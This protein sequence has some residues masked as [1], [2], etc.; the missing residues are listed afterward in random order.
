[1]LLLVSAAEAADRTSSV[2][3]AWK[4]QKRKS[5]QRRRRVPTEIWSKRLQILKDSLDLTAEAALSLTG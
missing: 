4:Y 5:H 1:L 3:L 2:D